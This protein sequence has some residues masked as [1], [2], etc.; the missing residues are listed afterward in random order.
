MFSDCMK[1]KVEETK[2]RV[3]DRYLHAGRRGVHMEYGSS[4]GVVGVFKWRRGIQV[5]KNYLYG[6][7]YSC[8]GRVF[9]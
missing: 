6:G 8:G 5:E 1:S 9:I 4:G 7:G 3:T 2:R